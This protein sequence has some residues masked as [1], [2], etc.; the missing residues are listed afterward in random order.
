MSFDIEKLK[1]ELGL[2][3]LDAVAKELEAQ[4]AEK[5]ETARQAAEDARIT[6]LIER[7]V[8]KEGMQKAADTIKALEERLDKNSDVF[9]KTV[10]QMQGEILTYQDQIKQVLAA[11]DGVSATAFSVSKA[12]FGDQESF[13]KEIENVVLLSYITEKG[14]FE[15]AYGQNHVK[16]V[17]ASSSIEVSSEGYETIFSNRILRDMQKLMVVGAMFEELPMTAKTLTMMIEP[18]AQQATWVDAP[19]FGTAT[20]QG[21]EVKVAMLEKSFKTWKLASKAYMTDETDEDAIVALLPII[22]R[23]LIESHV[24]AV[25]TAFMTGDGTAKP[26]GLLKLAEDAS[27]KIATTATADGT[28]VVTAKDILRL[29]RTLGIYG[30]DASK[31]ALV[32]SMDAYYDLLED[33]GWQDVD[34]V[35]GSA[36]KLQGQ[37]GR[38]YGLPVLVS[39]YFPTKA[40]SAEF[41]ALVYRDNFVVPRQRQVTVEA[42]REASRGRDAYYVTQ[43]LNLQALIDNKGVV[44]GTYAA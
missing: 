7:S 24:R 15:T 32:V 1:Q 11:R 4:K 5:A 30:L 12:M 23:H 44:T 8:D 3:K 41:C 10:E 17:N 40:A 27:A 29:R 34:K 18:E 31:L 42:E 21:S 9:A 43:R 22:R 25:E 14:T 20:S 2:D 13:E 36:I 28:T 38:I 6:A 19:A 35:G 39:N 37:V 16:A 33:E 26:A